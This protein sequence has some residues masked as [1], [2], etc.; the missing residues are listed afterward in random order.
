MADLLPALKG[1]GSREGGEVWGYIPSSRG[2]NPGPGL[3]P[4]TPTPGGTRG[5]GYS[6]HHRP[7]LTDLKHSSPRLTGLR[8]FISFPPIP[9]LKGEAFSCNVVV[10]LYVLNIAKKGMYA[11][12]T[13]LLN[14]SQGIAAALGSMV[15]GMLMDVASGGGSFEPLRYY[16]LAVAALRLALS[17][18]F[19]RIDDVR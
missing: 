3:R 9:A 17:L 4:V 18:P 13:A 1:E 5:Y 8:T 7:R 19:L 11:S 6:N 16:F 14:F 12:Y 15:G 2:F 10:P